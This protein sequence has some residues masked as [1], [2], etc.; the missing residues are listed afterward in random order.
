MLNMETDQ[1]E[2]RERSDST[3]S[4]STDR[5][6]GNNNVHRAGVETRAMARVRMH[7]QANNNMIVPC[8]QQGINNNINRDNDITENDVLGRLVGVETRAMARLRMQQANNSMIV[9][10]DRRRID[11]NF[12]RDNETEID[13]LDND[14]I[15]PY[16]ASDDHDSVDLSNNSNSG[17]E[18]DS[19][20]NDEISHR[21]ANSGNDDDSD[22]SDESSNRG[23]WDDDYNASDM[24]G[25]DPYDFFDIGVDEEH[26]ESDFEGIDMP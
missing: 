5:I 15:H 2:H 14:D 10:C 7:Q 17:N 13:V 22:E 3:Q 1:K 24:E 23:A 21:G 11:N 19:D 12:N 26:N 4:H 18:D 16:V 25:I 20:E 8:D 9:P 6:G